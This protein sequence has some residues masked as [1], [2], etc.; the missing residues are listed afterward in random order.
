MKN[1]ES[2]N[3]CFNIMKSLLPFIGMLLII[4]AFHFTDW[5]FFKFYPPIVNLGLFIIFFSSIFQKQTVI[6]KLALSMEPDAKPWVLDY[7]RKLTYIWS[8]FMFLNFLI[9]AATIFMSKEIWALYNGIISYILVGL[10]F[11]VEYTIRMI[12]KRKYD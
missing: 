10:L 9:S 12:F 2:M 5:I 1:K 7:T 3:K 11:G 4:I 8:V 6:Q